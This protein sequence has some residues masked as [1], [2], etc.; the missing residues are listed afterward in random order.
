VA[1]YLEVIAPKYF[2]YPIPSI[3]IGGG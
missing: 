2:I 3:P 1:H